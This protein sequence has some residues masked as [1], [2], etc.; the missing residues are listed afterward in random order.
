MDM[1]TKLQLREEW[2]SLKTLIDRAWDHDMEYDDLDYDSLSQL[3]REVGRLT[4]KVNTLRY[5]DENT[6]D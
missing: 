6:S 2:H 4:S 1:L 5:Q 3:F